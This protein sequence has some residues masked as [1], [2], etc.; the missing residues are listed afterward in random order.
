MKFSEMK[1]LSKEALRKQYR[2][3]QE[4]LVELKMKN[5]LGQITNPLKMRFLRKDIARTKTALKMGSY[6]LET[7]PETSLSQTSLSNNPASE[8]KSSDLLETTKLSK[9]E[10]PKK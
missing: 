8:K 3:F 2:S 4:E 9:Q 1:N 7:P 10:P 5:A 6:L